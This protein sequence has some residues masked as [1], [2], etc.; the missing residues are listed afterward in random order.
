MKV[1][2]NY[3]FFL[4]KI[5]G[6]FSHPLAIFP[7]DI[8]IS[9]VICALEKNLN[10]RPTCQWRWGRHRA[11]LSEGEGHVDTMRRP[12]TTATRAF[13]GPTVLTGPVWA[14]PTV[15]MPPSP[16]PRQWDTI[17][18]TEY[19]GL[20]LTFPFPQAA[21]V[22]SEP[23]SAVG[24]CRRRRASHRRPP[25]VLIWCHRS[26]LELNH[27]ATVPTSLTT[28]ATCCSSGL[29]SVSPSAKPPPPP[30]ALSGEPI[31]SDVPQTSPPHHRAALATI[32]NP[33]HRR[34]TPESGRPPPPPYLRV[35]RTTPPASRPLRHGPRTI[36]GPWAMPGAVPAGRTTLW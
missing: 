26:I 28:S 10:R 8:L 27:D 5:S 34:Q 24:F 35:E 19:S 3:T 16:C 25:R 12:N 31:L 33:P 21:A 17:C 14:R 4:H 32:H 15:S 18:T 13:K 29:A 11:H 9:A 6:N 7:G 36:T 22:P 1:V 23:S 30:R 20:P 2:P